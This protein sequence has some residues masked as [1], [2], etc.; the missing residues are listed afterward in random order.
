MA[1]A[2]RNDQHLTAQLHRLMPLCETLGIEAS[3]LADPA[4]VVVTMAWKPNLCTTGGLLHG[5]AVMSVADAA[6][7]LCAFL[8]LPKGASG[9]TTIQSQTN[10]LRAVREGA[11]IRARAQP[12]HA[13]GTVIV[14]ETEIRDADGRL[15]AKTVQSQAVLG[16]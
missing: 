1:E 12:L 3:S 2:P 16:R 15:I 10:F 14:V 9:T 11:T 13:G 8:N 5:G 4:E 6:G 7:G